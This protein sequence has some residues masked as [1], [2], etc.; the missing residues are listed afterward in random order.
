M[1][2]RGPSGVEER[3]ML[4][5]QTEWSKR[6]LSE[7]SEWSGQSGPRI[8]GLA[9][10]CLGLGLL[11]LLALVVLPGG[12]AGQST[13]TAQQGA[14]VGTDAAKRYAASGQLTVK[15][16]DALGSPFFEGAEVT[17]LTS[18]VAERYSMKCDV[19][20]Q[21]QFSA[22][23]IG[24]YLVEIVA[25]GYRTVQQQVR[26]SGTSE[27][28]D[29][30]VS[31]VPKVSGA[32]GKSKGSVPQQA[33]KETEKAL[34]AMQANNLREAESHLQQALTIDLDFAD[35][36]YLMGM[37]LLKQK[38]AGRAAAYLQKSLG[39]A[40][41]H[42]Q[43]LL[44]LGEAQYLNHDYNHARESLEKFLQEYP[45]SPQASV[46]QKYVNA[47]DK[48]RL[49]S[50]AAVGGPES[51]TGGDSN[52]NVAAENGEA[53]A[54]PEIGPVTELNWAPPDVDEEKVELT[55]KDGCQLDQ[56]VDAAGNRVQ[57]LVTN[58]DHFT[59]TENIQHTNVSP[60]GLQTS[61]ED[62]KFS[63]LVE[64][65]PTA[66]KELSVEEYRTASGIKKD[67][68]GGIE[69]IGL[70]SL[71]LIFHPYLR[72][73]YDFQCEGRGAWRGKAAWVVHFQQRADQK[74]GML[75]YHVGR[76]YI[77]VGL[78]GRAW[79]DAKT[80]QI[81]AMESDIMKPIPEIKL[82]RDHQ[83]VEYGPVSFRKN[84]TQLWLPKSA[85]WYC[86][87]SGKRFYR[88]HTFSQFLLFS[89]DDKQNISAPQIPAEP[90]PQ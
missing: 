24:S 16:Q 70:P 65:H 67:F 52:G 79:V 49:G 2:M 31:M 34:R 50:A 32:K 73:R 54:L 15:V 29:M 43:V 36:N 19:G 85:D 83:L 81:V 80:S 25:P 86:S 53:A 14:G 1:G 37:L 33:V 78:K 60:M 71:A 44:A 22:L 4:S 69:T 35:A 27:G 6:R 72:E 56:V 87:I 46:A 88:R 7:P 66:E 12:L 26:I 47:I 8:S 38:D 30:V 42:A 58:V 3:S 5:A 77:A 10:V 45:G 21:A 11:G 75:T 59:A 90:N 76:R 9:R 40:P 89:V 55:A 20:G 61:R 64:I 82:F 23:P 74:N 68:P 17:V 41:D 51:S 28:Q 48:V 57:E 62:R 84:T 39:I 13:S 18:D 63:Y